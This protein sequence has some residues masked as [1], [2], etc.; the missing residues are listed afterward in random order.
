MIVFDTS[1]DTSGFFTGNAA[2]MASLDAAGAFFSSILGDNLNDLY[3]VLLHE[4]GHVLGIGTAD[5]WNNLVSGGLFTGA[6]SVASYG[7][8]VPLNPTGDHWAEGTKS[9]VYGTATSQEAA[10]DPTLTV[11]TR[12]LFTNLDVA[13][14]QDVGWQIVAVPEPSS[15]GLCGLGLLGMAAATR[16]GRREAA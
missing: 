6:A 12:K 3:S 1:T 2:A 10:M 11:G 14:L 8:S 16:F 13:G 9:T 4:I 5:S 7:G 15:L